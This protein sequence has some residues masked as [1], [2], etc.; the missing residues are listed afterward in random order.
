MERICNFFD[1]LPWNLNDSLMFWI[2]FFLIL[3]QVP[4]YLLKTE[5]VLRHKHPQTSEA[6]GS[7]IRGA[8][9]FGTIWR[10]AKRSYKTGQDLEGESFVDAR[11]IRLLATYPIET[12]LAIVLGLR[13]FCYGVGTA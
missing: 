4:I 9:P 3:S 5:Q 11:R 10:L 1:L 12:A 7:L 6:L 13:L 8:I 2:A